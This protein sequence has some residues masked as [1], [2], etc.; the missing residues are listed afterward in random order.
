MVSTADGKVTIGGRSGPIGNEADRKLFHRLRTQADAVMV[1]A[2]TLR[3]EG[4]RRL[5]RDPDLRAA[6]VAEG[7]APDPLLVVVSRSG[8]VPEIEDQE[9]VVLPSPAGIPP[10]RE[11][12]G[13]RSILCEGGPTLND[14]LLRAGL[15]DELFLSLA[16]KLSGGALALTAVAGEPLPEPVGMD[17]LSVLE[18][19]GHLFLRYRLDGTAFAR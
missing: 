6:R 4:Y 7:L 10:L 14:G 19:E 11:S 1:G 18:S 5:V 17:L 13:I 12:H 9:M 3:I 8:D 2:G 16:P 15:V